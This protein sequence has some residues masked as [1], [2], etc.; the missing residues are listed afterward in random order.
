MVYKTLAVRVALIAGYGGLCRFSIHDSRRSSRGNVGI[1]AGI[2]KG[3]GKGGKPAL[4]LSMLS[5]PRH[6][7]GLFFAILGLTL[8]KRALVGRLSGGRVVPV[9]GRREILRYKCTRLR[10]V[11]S[12]FQGVD[13]LA[14]SVQSALG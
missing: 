8:V 11:L 3:C 9:P 10:Y 14:S 2:S 13:R 5:T 6:F 4:W 12:N 1:P 7:H